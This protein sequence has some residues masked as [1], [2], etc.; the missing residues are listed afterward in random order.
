MAGSISS[1]RHRN[2]RHCRKTS[3]THGLSE[4]IS[5]IKAKEYVINCIIPLLELINNYGSVTSQKNIETR[6]EQFEQREQNT[7]QS[8]TRKTNELKPKAN[9]QLRRS[10]LLL[11]SNTGSHVITNENQSK[12]ILQWI[13]D[14]SNKLNAKTSRKKH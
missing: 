10:S 11:H 9:K 14:A 3:T 1:F 7:N 13:L 6:T 5:N 2:K 8:D 4:P 12:K